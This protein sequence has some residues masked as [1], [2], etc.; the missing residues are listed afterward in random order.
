[1]S[2][3][4]VILAAGTSSRLGVLKQLARLQGETLLDRSVRIARQAGCHPIVVVLGAQAEEIRRVCNLG[5]VHVVI[6]TQWAS[7][8]GASLSTGIQALSQEP[9]LHGAIVMACD[10]P[11]VSAG[12]LVRLAA[13]H[14]QMTASVYAGH[15]G[16]PAYFP[17]DAWPSLLTLRHDYGARDLLASA[18]GI[19]LEDGELDVDTPADLE[20]LQALEPGHDAAC[21]REMP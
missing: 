4:A 21:R 16:V 11:A 18:P 17:R 3:G 19:P 12:H 13:E 1:M 6:N 20:R 5:G 2:T 10:M 8:M 7:G 9:A 14:G 15:K